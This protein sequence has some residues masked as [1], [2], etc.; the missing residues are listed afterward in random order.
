MNETDQNIIARA[1]KT[2]LSLELKAQKVGQNLQAK[3]EQGKCQLK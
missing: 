1:Q 3:P 2:K